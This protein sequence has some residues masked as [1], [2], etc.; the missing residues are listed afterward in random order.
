MSAISSLVMNY[1][2]PGVM[3]LGEAGQ[4]RAEGKSTAAIIARGGAELGLWALAPAVM[5][6]YTGVGLAYGA[7]KV[8]D[9]IYRQQSSYIR[10]ARTPFSHSY[11]HSDASMQA[12]QRGMAAIGR[13][14]N[15]VGSEAAVMASMYSRR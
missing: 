6:V 1:A 8:G 13:A 15:L 12:Q 9:A 3:V 4:A 11:A 5:G 2:L 10:T 7:Y 14:R